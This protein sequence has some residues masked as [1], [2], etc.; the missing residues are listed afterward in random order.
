MFP[1]DG[2][3]AR[4]RP[5]TSPDTWGNSTGPGGGSEAK[6]VGTV[7]FGFARGQDFVQTEVMLFRGDRTKVRSAAVKHALVRVLSLVGKD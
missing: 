4:I 1:P 3:R 6:P 2:S 5:W 7:W